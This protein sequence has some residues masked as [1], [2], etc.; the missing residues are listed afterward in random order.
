VAYTISLASQIGPHFNAASKN[1]DYRNIVDYYGGKKHDEKAKATPWNLKDQVKWV[2]VTGKYF[3]FMAVPDA[4]VQGYTTTLATQTNPQLGPTTRIDISR[5]AIKTG[6]QT[7]VYY[8]YFGPKTSAD[9]KR[10]NFATDN[11]FQRAD[12]QLDSVVGSGWLGWLEWL[13][14]K[15]LNFFYILIPNYGVSIILVTILVKAIL[16]PLTKKGS[17]S[18][19]RMQELQPKMQELQ[20]KYKGNPQKLN[21]EMAELYK[22]EGANPMSGCLPLLIQFPIFIAMYNLFNTHFDLR[23]ALFIPGWIPDLS[24][25]ESVWN[26]GS[27]KIPFLGWNDLR[28][29]PIIYLLS[30]L[31]Y[32]KFTQQPTTGQTAAQMK[33]MMYGMPIVFF[34]ILYDVPSGL[35]VYWIA[36]NLLTIAQQIVINDILKKRKKNLATAPVVPPAKKR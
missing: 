27:F 3:S 25:P 34:F 35:L 16:F 10:Y 36:S 9:L 4:A 32:G 28:L 5:P 17:V 33:I 20:A 11:A 8:F 7:D 15:A 23:G 19:A 22:R 12:L 24:M 2:G 30:Q 21:A 31:F 1:S 18:S 14:K 26:F 29:L 13:L 6:K